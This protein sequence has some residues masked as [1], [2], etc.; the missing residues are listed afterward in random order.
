VALKV[1]QFAPEDGP[2][3]LERF[4]REALAAAKLRHANLCEVYDVGMVDGVHY[5]TMAYIEGQSLASYVENHAGLSQRMIAMIVAKLAR[6]LKIAHEKDVIHRDLKPSNVMMQ[7][8]GGIAEPVIVDFGLARRIDPAADRLTRS[9]Q[10][11]GT[12]A[13]MTPEQLCGARDATGPSCDIYAL[14]VILYELLTG[15]LPYQAP[16]QVVANEPDPPSMYRED[17]DPRLEEICSKAMAKKKS[18][19]YAT[20]AELAKA[21]SVYLRADA[22]AAVPQQPETGKPVTRNQ[23]Q[24]PPRAKARKRKGRPWMLWGSMAAGVLL[25]ASFAGIVWHA[26][27]SELHQAPAKTDGPK[28]ARREGATTQ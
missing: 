10:L 18:D 24:E 15:R 6:A 1:P 27:R 22:E 26:Y 21:L 14:G 23:V 5:L 2:E 25:I 9:G 8:T 16:G 7:E 17:L 4:K 13:Y 12:W 11:I 20:M 19:R 28:P 3:A